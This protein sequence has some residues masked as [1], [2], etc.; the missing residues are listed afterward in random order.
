VGGESSGRKK[1]E[2]KR[3]KKMKKMKTTNVLSA[4]IPSKTVVY[5]SFPVT[6]DIMFFALQNF[7]ITKV[8]GQLVQS[9]GLSATR[10]KCWRR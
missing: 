6:I 1:K 4:S 7:E 9:A 5:A 8:P 3:T 2:K 10:I